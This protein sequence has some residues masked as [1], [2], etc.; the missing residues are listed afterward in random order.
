MLESVYELLRSVGFFHPIHPAITHIPM[1]MIIGGF[2]FA[3]GGKFLH[4]VAFSDTAYYCY[5]LALIFVVPTI[6]TGYMDWQ[7]LQE[8][9][10]IFLIK[11]KMVLA[12]ILCILLVII[13]RVGIKRREN[14]ILLL[15]LYG[16]C[17]ITATGLGFSGGELLYG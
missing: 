2:V 12:S 15:I 13:A 5:C 14:E 1:G 7:V 16:L 4:K 3:L 11:L 9:K 10:W 17:L 6:L 8:G